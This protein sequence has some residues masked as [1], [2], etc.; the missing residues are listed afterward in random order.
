MQ[1]H[2]SISDSSKGLLSCPSV[3]EGTGPTMLNIK[4]VLDD[5]YPGVK[6]KRLEANYTLH[7]VPR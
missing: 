3:Q 7:L 6:G 5:Y 1:E 2:G 4:W